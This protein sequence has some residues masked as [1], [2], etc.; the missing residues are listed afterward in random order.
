MGAGKEEGVSM[1]STERAAWLV[2]VFLAGS[3][4]Y[5]VGQKSAT[6]TQEDRVVASV[7]IEGADVSN[8]ISKSFGWAAAPAHMNVEAVDVVKGVRPGGED[9]PHPRPA[10]KLA[11]KN[12]GDED[13]DSFG[14]NV[15]VLDEQ[16]KRRV[17]TYGQ[18]SGFINQGWTSDRMLFDATETDWKDIV[19]TNKID[20]PVTM[21]FY[22]SVSDGDKDV[23][24]VVFEPWELESLPALEH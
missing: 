3:I 22:A 18:A 9:Y 7:S 16:N 14:I 4:G 1:S 17:A 12:V 20:F 5:F 6:P 15:L 24:R 8:E 21:I 13:L 2:I 23:L 19:G 11:L 10:V